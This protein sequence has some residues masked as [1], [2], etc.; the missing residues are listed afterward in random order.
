MRVV[1]AVLNATGIAL[2]VAGAALISGVWLLS[3]PL[4]RDD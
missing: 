3:P 1:R 2:M 4:A